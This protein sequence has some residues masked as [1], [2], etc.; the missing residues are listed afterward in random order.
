MRSSRV[1]TKGDWM[2]T[3]LNIAP[4]AG[5]RTEPV[6]RFTGRHMVLIMVAFFGI[7]IGVNVTLAWFATGSWTGLVVPNSYVASQEFNA[8]NAA[9]V[10]AEAVGWQLAAAV[11]AGHLVIRLR[12]AAGQPLDGVTVSVTAGRPVHEGADRVL[13]VEPDVPGLYRTA[14]ALAAG[15]WNLTIDLSRDDGG[16]TRRLERLVRVHVPEQAA[17]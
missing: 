5:S 12:D 14:E 1:R 6:R 13:T 16:M 3:D 17:P 4:P 10:R 7:V 2:P 9:R 11:E 15:E 8:R